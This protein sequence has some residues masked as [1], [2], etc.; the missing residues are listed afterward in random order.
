MI[1]DEMDL[2]AFAP[3]VIFC[4][5]SSLASFPGRWP[6][7]WVSDFHKWSH[8]LCSCLVSQCGKGRSQEY[9]KKRAVGCESCCPLCWTIRCKDFLCLWLP[10]SQALMTL[11][12][13]TRVMSYFLVF[14]AILTD[15][16]DICVECATWILLELEPLLISWHFGLCESLWDAIQGVME[17]KCRQPG[18]SLCGCQE[19]WWLTCDVPVSVSEEYMS[20]IV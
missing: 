11:F 9:W 1:N 7:T 10:W 12:I 13:A 2:L 19:R 5:F 8:G 6:V 3:L 17:S 14:S 15:S 16:P 20:R 4:P 18:A